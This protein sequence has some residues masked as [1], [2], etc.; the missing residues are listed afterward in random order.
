M[1]HKV[2]KRSFSLRFVWLVSLVLFA[3]SAFADPRG[4]NLPHAIEV[5]TSDKRPMIDSDAKGAGDNV[6]GLKITVY[7]IDGIQSVE[8]DLSLSLPVEPRQAKQIALHRIENLDEQ[9]RASM[10]TAATALVKAMQVGLD[11]Y[12]AV[13]FDG[14]AVVY[15]VTDLTVALEQYRAWQTGRR[16]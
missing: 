9:T 12:P 1:I 4:S 3:D 16:P 8:R 6:R 14:E 11:R 5:F 7:K 10:H 2:S 15:G 13:V